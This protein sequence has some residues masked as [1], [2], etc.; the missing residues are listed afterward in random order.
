MFSNWLSI[1]PV[2]DGRR[3]FP[4]SGACTWNDVPIY[5]ITIHLHRHSISRHS[6]SPVH[7]WAVSHSTYFS[8]PS[9]D[10]IS[11]DLK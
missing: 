2:T 7:T 10:Q 9:V 11:R 5:F 8:K 6:Y 4:V 1:L 3:A